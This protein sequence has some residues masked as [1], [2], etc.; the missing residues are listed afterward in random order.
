MGPV[1]EYNVLR[2]LNM[3][4]AHGWRLGLGGLDWRRHCSG[5]LYPQTVNKEWFDAVS[6]VNEDEL[7]DLAASLAALRR[8]ARPKATEQSPYA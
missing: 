3:L 5:A 2:K 7:L 4:E 1:S 8:Q 6:A